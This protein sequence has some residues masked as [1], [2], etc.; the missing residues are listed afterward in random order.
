MNWDYL[1]DTI[2]SKGYGG[3]NVK[4]EWIGG[5]PWA[6]LYLFEQDLSELFAFK[7]NIELGLPL[8]QVKTGYT[9]GVKGLNITR[10]AEDLINSI[11]DI[12]CADEPVNDVRIFSL[13]SVFDSSCLFHCFHSFSRICIVCVFVDGFGFEIE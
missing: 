13:D 1:K 7:V 12:S 5:R 9:M 11:Q 10:V 8:G 2:S 3:S 6:I 4:L